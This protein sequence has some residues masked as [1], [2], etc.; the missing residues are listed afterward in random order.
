MWKILPILISFAFL[1]AGAASA[2]SKQHHSHRHDSLRIGVCLSGGGALGFA[3]LG[4]LQALN[5]HG[6]F[7]AEISGASMGAIVGTLYAA[8]YSPA[9]IL[10]IVKTEKMYRDSHIFAPTG[11]PVWKTSGLSSHK[12]LRSLL[13]KYIAHNSFEG[14]E[15][16][17]YICVTNLNKG[18]YEIISSGGDLDLWVAASASIPGVFESLLINENYYS[19]GGTV[20]N[21]PVEPLT[22]HCN[23]IIGIDVCPYIPTDEYLHSITGTALLALRL[24]QKCNTAATKDLCNMVIE[25]AATSKY[26]EFDFEKYEEIYQYGYDAVNLW[27]KEHPDS[28]PAK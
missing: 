3:H 1:Q 21:L 8:G 11:T 15:K 2:Q 23:F 5:E 26:N 14:L 19:D 28:H 4:A 12:K 24:G 9:Q 20:N 10:G 25:S 22:K 18:D 7:P 6:I 13:R 16:K 27:F 17:L